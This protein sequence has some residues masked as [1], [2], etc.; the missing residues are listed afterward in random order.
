MV[1]NN[2][3]KW[4]KILQET[5]PLKYY[6]LLIWNP[7]VTRHPAFYPAAPHPRETVN[8]CRNPGLD[9]ALPVVRPYLWREGNQSSCVESWPT[10]RMG[11]AVRGGPKRSLVA[12]LPRHANEP[13][14]S[15]STSC[16]R[17]VQKRASF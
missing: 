7:D 4:I 6:A 9:A 3:L 5:Y 15:T 10:P 13:Q 16:Q 11:Q 8:L 12:S 1:T 17:M 2:K 14:K